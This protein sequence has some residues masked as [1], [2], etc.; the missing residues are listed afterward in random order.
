VL[1]SDSALKCRNCTKQR[2][3]QERCLQS[4]VEGLYSPP[5][6]H[7]SAH[8][9]HGT[10]GGGR[11]GRSATAANASVTRIDASMLAP[12]LAV[13]AEGRA[14]SSGVAQPALPQ[15]FG[16]GVA[17]GS[18]AQ[19]P[20]PHKPSALIG[21]VTPITENV[22]SAVSN[23]FSRA[24]VGRTQPM[25]LQSASACVA[26]RKSARAPTNESR[27]IGQIPGRLP[28]KLAKLARF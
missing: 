13:A 3:T 11:M 4:T 21:S 26:G 17:A 8:S 22:R 14:L 7:R 27:C 15:F 9:A 5:K 19:L 12:S 1:R 6:P 25:L 28:Q 10:A 2:G 16:S 20:A 24:L 18:V 23:S